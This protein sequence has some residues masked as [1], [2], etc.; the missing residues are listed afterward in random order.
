MRFLPEGRR[1]WRGF[2]FRWLVILALL[3]LGERFLIRMPG[4]SHSGPLPP[5][6]REELVTGE[7]L[8]RHVQAL[9]G[10]IGERNMWRPQALE[11]AA[12]Y[13]EGEFTALGYEVRRQPFRVSNPPGEA[14]NLAVEVPRR[15]GSGEIVVL[16][17]HYD[18][19]RGSPG[20]NDNASGV[21]ALIELARLLKDTGPGR[22]LRLVAFA[23]E[24]PPFFTTGE[25]GS[26]VHARQARERGERV[27]AMLALETLGY[28]SDQPESQ[29]YPFPLGLIYPGTGNF[30][31]FVGNLGS[32]SLVRRCVELFR[33]AAAFPSEGGALPGAIPGVGWSDHW[34]FWQE[35]YEAVMVTDTALYR[36]PWYHL[37]GD[38]PE[39]VDYGRL[40]RVTHGLAVVAA[41]LAGAR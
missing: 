5:L 24:E 18:S 12:A 1:G 41:G 37:P 33:A 40:A 13:I 14:R 4:Q 7:R 28:Y 15:G 32:A 16:G 36:Y 21:A 20:A 19:V 11:A 2:A 34:S 22:R 27:S 35:G 17:A 38:T 25:M 29:Q 3:V 9:A 26:Q 6:T 31:G 39:R 23:N 8:R 30:V 10:D